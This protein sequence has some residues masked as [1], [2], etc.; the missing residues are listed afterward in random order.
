MTWDH[1][2]ESLGRHLRRADSLAA[3]LGTV[4]TGYRH[5]M[6]DE[7]ADD[8]F[9]ARVGPLCGWCDYRAACGPG[10]SVP[11]QRPWAAV[12]P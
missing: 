6:T 8:A 7:Q 5:G 11:A 3:E 4:D 10:R 12:G 9:P 2:E 1:T